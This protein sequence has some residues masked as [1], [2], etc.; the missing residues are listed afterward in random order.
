MSPGDD[1]F[2][3]R[4]KSDLHRIESNERLARLQSL[5]A[6]L[7]AEQQEAFMLL[8]IEEMDVSDAAI[9]MGCSEEDVK[10]HYSRAVHAL[11]EKLGDI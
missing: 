3:R 6:E 10:T 7:P 8:N 4:L 11:R 9:A 2:E 1:E 5:I